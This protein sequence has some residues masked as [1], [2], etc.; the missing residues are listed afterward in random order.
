MLLIHRCDIVEPIEI[1]QRL[2]IGLVFD[3]FLGA[4]MEKPDMRIDPLD[5][6]AIEL[7]G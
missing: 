1:R 6:L 5:D 4:A 7:K 2:K 3:Q